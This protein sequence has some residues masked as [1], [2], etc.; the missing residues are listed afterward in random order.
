MTLRSLLPLAA[1]AALTLLAACGTYRPGYRYGPGPVVATTESR[2]RVLASVVG[3]RR[4]SQDVPE[5]V[6]VRLRVE[7]P[8][9]RAVTLD[10][11][12]LR[13]VSADLQELPLVAFSPQGDESV[14]PGTAKQWTA[15]FGLPEGDAD[16]VDLNGLDV[17]WRLR[18]GPQSVAEGHAK[19]ERDALEAPY[20][21]YSPYGHWGFGFGYGHGHWSHGHWGHGH[22]GHGGWHGS[23]GYHW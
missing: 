1:C 14:S 16:A 15:W 2:A 17:R 11:A 19:F 9:D 8:E 20:P 22:W 18:T 13:A 4:A 7:A 10:R 6:E 5:S 23:I 12:A 3:L 21:L